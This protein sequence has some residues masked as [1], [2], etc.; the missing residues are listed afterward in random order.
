ML[1]GLKHA[2][3]SL[4]VPLYL[5]GVVARAGLFWTN[6]CFPLEGCQGGRSFSF[7]I[8]S[9]SGYLFLHC[10]SLRLVSSTLTCSLSLTSRC[11]SIGLLNCGTTSILM[12]SKFS[13]ST[14]R[15]IY[16]QIQHSNSS[17]S[18]R[19]AE[20]EIA[21]GHAPAHAGS[22]TPNS[23]VLFSQNSIPRISVQC[24]LEA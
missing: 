1:F 10:P 2:I 15:R 22:W 20:N 7:C 21:E 5:L 19:A 17:K 8:C 23:D 13:N 18:S 9:R 14:H 11:W 24:S 4:I 12:R 6:G 16:K 3:R